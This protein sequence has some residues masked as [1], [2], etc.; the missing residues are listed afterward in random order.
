MP[1]KKARCAP[2]SGITLIET[3]L[4]LVILFIAT[5]GLLSLAAVALTTSENG[6]HLTAR[7]TEYAQDK[8]EQLIAL[9]Y[10]NLNAD[11]TLFPTDTSV[12]AAGT[13]LVVGGDSDPASADDGYVDYLSLEGEFL[14]GGVI[15]PDGAFYTRAWQ[16]E[17]LVAGKLKRITVTC[18]VRAAAGARGELPSATLVILKANPF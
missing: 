17:E 8:V 2:E 1:F 16:V 9:N 11:T 10:G 13:G 14:G 6:G 12:G 3:A 18:Q 15:P 5:S 4:A 7:A